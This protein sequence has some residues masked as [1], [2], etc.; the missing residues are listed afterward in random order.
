VKEDSH[1]N[2]MQAAVLPHTSTVH[3]A[4]QP[5]VHYSKMQQMVSA[6]LTPAVS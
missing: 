2:E 5:T 6:F 4:L 1:A 3:I